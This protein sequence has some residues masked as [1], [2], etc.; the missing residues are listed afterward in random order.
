METI[1]ETLPNIG[2]SVDFI[3]LSSVL[4]KKYTDS[5]NWDIKMGRQTQIC[6]GAV[7]GVARR[8]WLE[9][10]NTPEVLCPI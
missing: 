7:H 4:H 2:H 10:A 1:L 3:A 5:V 9:V 6:G 8:A